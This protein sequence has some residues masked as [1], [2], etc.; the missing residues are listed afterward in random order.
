MA[1]RR[2][3]N[4]DVVSD[5]VE[6]DNAVHPPPL[7]R[8]LAVQLETKFDKERDDRLEVVDNDADVVHPQNRHIPSMASVAERRCC[9]QSTY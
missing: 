8:P 4:G 2:P 1:V 5:T 7:D 9:R 3:Q 6:P